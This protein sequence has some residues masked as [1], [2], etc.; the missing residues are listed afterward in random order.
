MSCVKQLFVN[1][2]NDLPLPPP[3]GDKAERLQRGIRLKPSK[4]DKNGIY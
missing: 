1:S 4:G 3:K 2:N